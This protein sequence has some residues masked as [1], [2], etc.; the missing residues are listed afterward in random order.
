M[1]INLCNILFEFLTFRYKPDYNDHDSDDDNM[2][3][4]Y[5]N[6]DANKYK[7]PDANKYKNPDAIEYQ[8]VNDYQEL[9]D[10]YHIINYIER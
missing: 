5:K 8:D 4:N 2:D 6:Q 9:D 3:I 10:S 1:L 7:N